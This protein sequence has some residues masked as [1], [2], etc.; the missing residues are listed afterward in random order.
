MSDTMTALCDTL[1]KREPVPGDRLPDTHKKAVTKGTAYQVLH[2]SEAD[3]GHIKVELNYNAGTWYVYDPLNNPQGHWDGPWDKDIGEA[4]VGYQGKAIVIA[5]IGIYHTDQPI[6]NGGSFTWGEATHEGQRIP[7]ANHYTNIVALATQL[8]KARKQIG[9][10]FRVTSWYCPNPWNARAGG[11]KRSQHLE[12]R[13]ADVVV[14]GLMG[15]DL[16]RMVS[17]WWPGG[18][19]IYPGNRQHILHLDVGPKRK[20][21]F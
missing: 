19:G 15:R 2:W 5:G 17:D 6:L 4:E 21:G 1:L 11:A 14:D 20:W 7:T 13:A 16:G 8:E 3:D 9:R 18:L 10:P 12:G